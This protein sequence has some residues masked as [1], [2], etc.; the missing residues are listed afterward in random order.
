MGRCAQGLGDNVLVVSGAIG[1]YDASLLRGILGS[2]MCG[3]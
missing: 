3:A 1:V 2:V